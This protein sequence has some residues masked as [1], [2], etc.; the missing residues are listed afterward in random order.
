MR[1]VTVKFVVLCL[2]LAGF[3]WA[4]EPLWTPKERAE[5]R[6]VVLTAEV[7]SVEQKHSVDKFYYLYTARLK[8]TGV[9]K[10]EMKGKPVKAGDTVTV[11]YESGPREKPPRCPRCAELRKGE[12]GT[13]YLMNL[14][15]PDR[16]RL[17]IGESAEG[18]FLQMGSDFLQQEN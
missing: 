15:T 7:V 5:K 8:V 12:R 1:G 13:F 18:F 6:D 10:A 2:F 16:Q 4:N 3:A 11:Y 9:E 17:E 14:T